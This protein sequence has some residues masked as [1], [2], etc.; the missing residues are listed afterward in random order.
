MDRSL[1]GDFQLDFQTSTNG[2]KYLRLLQETWFH[3]GLEHEFGPGIAGAGLLT[4]EVME[5]KPG[6]R[7]KSAA[8]Q[9]LLVRGISGALVLRLV[10]G[11][12]EIV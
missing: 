9:V 12:E 2:W 1:L 8:R 10:S 3:C 4:R 5:G 7:S 11:Q 6:V